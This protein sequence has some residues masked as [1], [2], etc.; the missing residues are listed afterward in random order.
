M[1]LINS[2]IF[3]T[4][5]QLYDFHLIDILLRIIVWYLFTTSRYLW[6]FHI[7][8]LPYW[9]LYEK[10][11]MPIRYVIDYLAIYNKHC[12]IEYDGYLLCFIVFECVYVNKKCQLISFTSVEFQLHSPTIEILHT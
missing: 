4:H 2:F 3:Q 1:K 11:Y 12:I 7:T 9:V 10:H 6:N 8:P 5:I